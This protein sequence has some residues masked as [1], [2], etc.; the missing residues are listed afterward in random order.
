M[1]TGWDKLENKDRRYIESEFDNDKLIKINKNIAL[2]LINDY[3]YPKKPI[4]F[5]QE[6]ERLDY[7]LEH[8][9]QKYLLNAYREDF[10]YIYLSE[11]LSKLKGKKYQSKRNHISAFS[12][13][14]DWQYQKIDIENIEKIKECAE[15]KGMS[16]N[17]LVISLLE[18]EIGEK[19]LSIREKNKLKKESQEAE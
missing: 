1:M 9:G 10:D 6:G 14:Y 15:S 3:C 2:K 16:I 19:I 13:K 4:F 7:F 11:D 12:R 17:K 18:K 5:A 8:Y